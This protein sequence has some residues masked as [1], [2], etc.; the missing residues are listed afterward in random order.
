MELPFGYLIVA[1]LLGYSV[2]FHDWNPQPRFPKKRATIVVRFEHLPH[3][4]LQFHT[5]LLCGLATKNWLGGQVS[6]VV[7]FRLFGEPQIRLR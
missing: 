7:Q 4:V 5:V 6:L 3:T 2:P 1:L